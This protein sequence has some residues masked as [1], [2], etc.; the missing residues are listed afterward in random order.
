MI[1]WPSL[2]SCTTAWIYDPMTEETVVAWPAGDM[3]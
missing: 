1:G 2:V 3:P